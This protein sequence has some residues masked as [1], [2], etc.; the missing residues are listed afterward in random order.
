MLCPRLDKITP[1]IVDT[2][3]EGLWEKVIN[4]LSQELVKSVGGINKYGCG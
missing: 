4:R 3:G 1:L 2:H